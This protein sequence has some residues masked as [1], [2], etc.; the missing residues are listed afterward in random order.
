MNTLFRTFLS[1]PL[2]LRPKVLVFAPRPR[3]VF[4]LRLG[5]GNVSSIE[6][7]RPS[8]VTLAL[9]WATV[10]APLLLAPSTVLNR[11]RKEVTLDIPR[12]SRL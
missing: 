8:L 6:T 2:L 10:R 1:R 3:L 4:V 9:P 11:L 12:V 5:L 7:P